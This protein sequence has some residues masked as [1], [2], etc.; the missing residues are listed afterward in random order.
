MIPSGLHVE[1]I[2][3][4]RNGRQVGVAVLLCGPGEA[5]AGEASACTAVPT[6]PP[7]RVVSDF[8]GRRGHLANA[9]RHTRREAAPAAGPD[10]ANRH[11]PRYRAATAKACTEG[12]GTASRCGSLVTESESACSRER[13]R[14]AT[15]SAATFTGEVGRGLFASLRS[16]GREGRRVCSVHRS[17]PDAGVR[18][19][20]AAAQLRSGQWRRSRGER[21]RSRLT[22]DF[23]NLLGF[24][25]RGQLSRSV[26]LLPSEDYVRAW[27]YRGQLECAPHAR[28]LEDASLL[29]GGGK[30]PERADGTDEADPQV[31][32]GALRL[33]S[34]GS[35]GFAGDHARRP[36]RAPARLD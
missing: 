12:C 13:L 1:G 16:A 36:A 31:R 10:T 33:T 30:W 5:G 15:S 9:L 29:K 6:S 35:S 2:G 24:R 21:A 34:A 26:R 19:P 23:V 28:G 32:Q 4:A 27:A 20:R 18:C 3:D 25:H 14:A 17:A 22:A 11:S 7:C 8:A